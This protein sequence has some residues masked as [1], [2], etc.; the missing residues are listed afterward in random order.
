V[1]ADR[2]AVARQEADGGE[3]C[4]YTVVKTVT[5]KP[6]PPRL[7]LSPPPCPHASTASVAKVAPCCHVR[8]CACVCACARACVRVCMC[9]CVCVDAC[10]RVCACVCQVGEMLMIPAKEARSHLYKLMSGRIVH[11]Q[12]R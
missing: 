2:A 10:A 9:V 7:L 5:S 1:R 11:L 3:V 6:R 8:V 4:T 12:V